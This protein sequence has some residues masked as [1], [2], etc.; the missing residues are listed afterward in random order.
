MLAVSVGNSPDQQPGRS[1][2]VQ[3]AGKVC[4]T[5]TASDRDAVAR[6]GLYLLLAFC[7]AHRLR[8]ASAMR[9]RA[10]G[11]NTRDFRAFAVV[12]LVLRSVALDEPEPASRER[13]WVSRAISESIWARID[14]IAIVMR[15]T[16]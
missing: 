14:S 8:C 1:R 11:L 2:N 6:G 15:I 7:A 16:H 3:D 5:V 10:S 4:Q 12:F 13:T 9:L